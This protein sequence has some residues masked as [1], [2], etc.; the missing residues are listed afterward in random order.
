MCFICVEEIPKRCRN[1]IGREKIVNMKAG[2]LN[3]NRLYFSKNIKA[4]WTVKDFF[5][6]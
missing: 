1:R 6:F 2:T 4:Q 5:C 3:S